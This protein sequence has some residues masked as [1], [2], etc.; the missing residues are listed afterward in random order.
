MHRNWFISDIERLFIEP[1]KA[2]QA[3]LF[4]RN[5]EVIGY[6][7]WAFFSYEAE[8]A[9]V[10]GKRKL[11]SDDE[12]RPCLDYRLHCAIRRCRIYRQMGER[13]PYAIRSEP[14]Y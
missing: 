11:Q 8:D 12:E 9:F 3:R 13:S 5:G 6:I 2:D 10:T 14:Q 1:L 7:S 4:Y